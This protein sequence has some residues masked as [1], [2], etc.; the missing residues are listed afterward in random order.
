MTK[1]VCGGGCG[2]H[3]IRPSGPMSFCPT[4]YW[5]HKTLLAERCTDTASLLHVRERCDAMKARL[6]DLVRRTGV[7]D[8]EI[9]VAFLDRA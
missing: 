8:A 1:Y 5:L 4:C 9:L 7:D 6:A 3:V 2:I